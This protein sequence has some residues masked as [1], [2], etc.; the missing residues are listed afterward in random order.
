MGTPSDHLLRTLAAIPV[1]SQILDLGCGDGL[2]TEPM[3]RLGFQVHACD[4]QPE[5]VA[6]TRDAVVDIVGAD[7]V[8]ECVR[9]V[10]S[11]SLTDLPDKSFDWV[12]AYRP[13]AYVQSTGD[14]ASVLKESRRLLKPGGWVYV[15]LPRRAN[16]STNGTPTAAT[17]SVNELQEASEAADL[18]IASKPE[19]AQEHGDDI[20]RAIFRRVEATTPS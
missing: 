18:A 8:D 6:A 15:A 2:H 12:I 16:V 5:A 19:V 13:S 11:E 7:T 20:V 14:V 4:A 3:L 1:S 9:R 17:F 10:S